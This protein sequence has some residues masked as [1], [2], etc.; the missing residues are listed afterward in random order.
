MT[1]TKSP[2][3]KAAAESYEFQAEVSKLLHLMV[4][5]VYSETEVFL[6]ELISNAAD[7]CDKL[8]YAGITE[9][10][11]VGEDADLKITITVDPQAK[12]IL[13]ADNGIGMSHDELIENLGTIA[14]SGTE[15]FISQLA[16]K[17]S[18]L[19][20]IG[21]FG[22]GFYSAF[23]VA[24][25][26]DVLSR[27]AGTDEAWKWTSDGS[28]RFTLEPLD[29]GA[30][31]AP[32]R[33]TVIRLHLR[34]DAAEYAEA[35]RIETIVRT[36]S[37]HISFP[38]TLNAPAEGE[39]PEE[40]RQLNSAS[41][42]WT[43][44]KSEITE[45]QYKEFYGHVAGLFD[46]PALTL[47]YKA[48]GRHEYTV[49][50]FVP[51]QRPFDLFDPERLAKLKLYVRRVFITEDASILPG[52]LRFA[53]GVIDSEDMPLN[54]SREMLQNNP[55][56]AAIRKAVTNRILSELEKAAE[57][58]PETYKT[59]WSNF[60]AVLKEGLYEDMERRDQLFNLARFRTTTADDGQ[61]GLKDYV[62]AMK[63][64]QAAIYYVTG[65]DAEKALAS[66]QLEGF[67]AKGVEVLVLSDPVDNFWI[68]SALGFDGKPFKSVTQGAADLDE[69]D[70]GDAA[71]DGDEA[72]AAELS[73]LIAVIKQTL[74]DDVSD[75]RKSARLT[76]S[77]A[78][79]V[80]EAGGL[81]RNLEKLL[82]Q[83]DSAG[84]PK[85]APVLEINPKHDMVKA[86]AG[87]AKAEG[88]T[89]DIEDA[90]RLLLD[91]AHILDGVPVKDPA[92][93]A[94]RLSRFMARGLG[95]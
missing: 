30:E 75:V 42:L 24:G 94:A 11:L 46:E 12:Q 51:G 4:H 87:A 37:D 86:L 1:S 27:R 18:D 82:A 41:A 69:I 6:R 61:R 28:G 20:L 23:M 15:A 65:E 74:G 26:V 78:C 57:K 62:A 34:E 95:A 84:M 33:G 66:P 29:A 64:S 79:L 14:R 93:F 76:D 68:T 16:G 59:I 31:D 60:G 25:E 53:R 39:D 3:D 9:P 50:L 22:V 40:P 71:D 56:V 77:A 67:R 55:I 44:P 54:I 80:A 88:A 36:Y 83:H 5:S 73:T 47:H 19:Q 92:G 52:Y 2:E 58:E 13:V 32:A 38:I 21:Q 7:A 85:V 48:E 8:R 10:A 43:R 90:A 81:D 70:G 91:Q 63:D 17:D 35:G 72:D 89:G 49:L 45:D